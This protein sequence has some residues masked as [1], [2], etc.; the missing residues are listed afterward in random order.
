MSI[1]ICTVFIMDT[2]NS[3]KEISRDLV[4]MNVMYFHSH[5]YKRFDVMYI[6]LISI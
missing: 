4:K 6:L 1:T 5:F 3:D 2:C